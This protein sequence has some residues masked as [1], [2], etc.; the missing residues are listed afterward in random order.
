M[1]LIILCTI[2]VDE[3]EYFSIPVKQT[4][5]KVLSNKQWW[6]KESAIEG[7]LPQW[8]I[9]WGGKGQNPQGARH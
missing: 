4:I 6:F 1:I 7:E 8:D 9:E 2:S 3:Y 5:S